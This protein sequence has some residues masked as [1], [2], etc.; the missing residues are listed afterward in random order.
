ME[1]TTGYPQYSGNGRDVGAFHDPG[2]ND[3]YNYR[4]GNENRL[5]AGSLD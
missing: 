4:E 1:G 5:L 2:I 3:E